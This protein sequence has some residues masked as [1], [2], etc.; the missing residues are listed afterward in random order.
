VIT[1]HYAHG[2]TL[3]RIAPLLE[4]SEW[5]VQM[6]RRQAIAELRSRLA[7]IGVLAVT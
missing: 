1:L 7:H 3:R 5:Q 6:A 2:M 4:M